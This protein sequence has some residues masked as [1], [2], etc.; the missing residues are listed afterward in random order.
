MP[1]PVTSRLA[2]GTNGLIAAGAALVRD[3][4]DVLELL[5]GPGAVPDS[6]ANLGRPGHRRPPR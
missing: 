2:E 1:G 3:A 6:V 4:R 5:L